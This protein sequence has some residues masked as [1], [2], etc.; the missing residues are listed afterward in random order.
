MARALSGVMFDLFN[1]VKL[2]IANT[3]M[4]TTRN[5]SLYSDRNDKL[6]RACLR[7]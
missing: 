4:A 7:K 5:P 2:G 3:N 1:F 6:P